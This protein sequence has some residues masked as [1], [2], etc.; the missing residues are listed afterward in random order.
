MTDA[1]AS[2]RG[3]RPASC[4]TDGN[5]R[6]AR[7][8]RRATACARGFTLV[9]LVV[10]IAL[11]AIVTAIGVSGRFVDCAAFDARAFAPQIAQYVAAGQ[12]IAVAQRRQ[13]FVD[14]DAGAGR[15]RLCLDAGCT[16]PIPAA[17]KL[18][19]TDPDWLQ[20]PSSLRL[21]GDA[22]SFSFGNDGTPTFAMPAASVTFGLADTSGTN[23]GAGAVVEGGSGHVR[24]F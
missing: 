1:L 10:V 13:V 3:C 18:S 5:P 2:D 8:G 14:V 11:V 23:L 19:T 15:I 9:E 4:A 21:S 20:V 22:S 17:P 24:A 6:G 12:R 16:Q 7:D